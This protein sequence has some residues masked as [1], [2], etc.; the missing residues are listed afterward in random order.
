VNAAKPGDTIAVYPGTYTEQV[1]IAT[2][3]ITLTT[4]DCRPDA[5]IQSPTF[6][7]PQSPA[8]VDAAYVMR[9][10][11]GAINVTINDFNINGG[12]GNNA[13]FGIKVDF[14][15][16]ATITNNDVTNIIAGQFGS[17]G[18]GAGID[19]GENTGTNSGVGSGI[20]CDNTVS[21]YGVVGIVVD[22]NQTGLHSTAAV[23]YNTVVG[24][25]AC[26][27]YVQYG[28]QVSNGASAQ[29]FSNDISADSNGANLAA[30]ILVVSAS[31]NVSILNNC[32][33]DNEYGIIVYFT[34][35]INV[36]GNDSYANNNDGIQLQGTNNGKVTYNFS[37]FNGGDGISVYGAV[38]NDPSSAKNNTVAD[39]VIVGNAGNG[40]T[41]QD[42]TGTKV[43]NNVIIGNGGDGVSID[44]SNGFALKFNLIV[45]SDGSMSVEVDTTDSSGN[46]S[47]NLIV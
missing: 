41:V 24:L 1:T 43:V 45:N 35:N 31:N 16:S 20:V 30:G 9:V 19:I 32:T 12:L 17:L 14:N 39:N 42:T 4:V 40:V 18:G 27:P 33:H 13:Q 29:V 7:T 34:N 28:T 47:S 8:D 3:N 15:A 11:G 6:A 44:D 2:S 37:G 26:A 5:T 36:T 22:G 23:A 38:N 21:G 25:G 10:T 46:V